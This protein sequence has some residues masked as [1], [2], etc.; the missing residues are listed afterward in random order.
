MKFTKH[1]KQYKPQ[2]YLDFFDVNLKKDTPIFIDPWLIQ[3]QASLNDDV[4]IES[5]SVLQDFFQT[6]IKTVTKDKNE[7]LRLLDE[8]HEPREYKIGYS[9]KNTDGLAIGQKH[10]L[11]IYEKLAKSE[12]VKSCVLSRLEDTALY[13]EGIDVDKISD[14]VGNI[15]RKPL[16][17]Y[18]ARQCKLLGID[19]V[20]FGPTHIWDADSHRWIDDAVLKLPADH[21]TRPVILI[22]KSFLSTELIINASDYYTHGILPFYQ[23]KYLKAGH[24]LCKV[25]VS[26]KRKGELKEP[27]K[28]DLKKELPYSKEDIF[29][30]S[31]AHPDE[32][33]K[34]R[35]GRS[36]EKSRV[37]GKPTKK[38]DINK[39]IRS[40]TGIDSTDD[41]DIQSKLNEIEPG[42]KDAYKYE[43]LISGLLT[44]IFDNELKN[45]IKQDP[46]D[47]GTRR[48]D[49][50]MTNLSKD[51]FFN[52]C[53]KLGI[54]TRF[55]YFEL[56]NYT[57]DVAN[58]EIDQLYGRFGNNTTKFGVIVCRK[59]KNRNLL[60][61]RIK[62]QII[63]K[64]EYMICLTDHDICELHKMRKS[65]NIEGIREHMNSLLDEFIPK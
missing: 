44:Y 36:P 2:A 53:S 35:N 20:E 46:I 8:L 49:I 24:K 12:A 51:G 59:V 62:D 5:L 3:R 52:D 17:D 60:I 50:T 58:A 47:E 41:I 65:E 56:K 4:A 55:I 30:F 7:S 15:I 16:S 37:N 14:L 64:A 1:H 19:L 25:L 23:K 11:Q 27:S 21:K 32:I 28:E 34:Y 18:T 48:V 43:D 57:E 26:G 29:D 39:L 13:I 54:I 42:K 31:L 40:V 38:A 33:K 45:P 61:K 9:Q 6:L 10:A 22:P 63:K